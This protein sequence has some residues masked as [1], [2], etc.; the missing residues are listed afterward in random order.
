MSLCTVLVAD[1]QIE[2]EGKIML[3]V[4]GSSSIMFNFIV[5]KIIDYCI[6]LICIMVNADCKL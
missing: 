5:I 4:V 2:E 1:S 6:F 3:Y